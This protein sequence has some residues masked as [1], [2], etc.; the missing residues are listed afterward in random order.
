MSTSTSRVIANIISLDGFVAGPNQSEERPFGDD[1]GD[2]FGDKLH[3]WMFDGPEENRAE[4]DEMAAY[5][6]VIMGR[7][8][9]GSS[10]ARPRSTSTWR[11]AWSTSC[12]C[13]SC[14]SRS[15]PAHDCSGASRR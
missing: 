7:N 5:R 3:A 11:P 8:M 6:A 12:G 14:L 9:F 1:G 4:I 10:A 13:T 2:G 15:V